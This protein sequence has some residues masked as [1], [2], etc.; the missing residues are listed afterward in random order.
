MATPIGT[1]LPAAGIVARIGAFP[2]LLGAHQRPLFGKYAGTFWRPA[3][4]RG[5][6]EFGTRAK[7]YRL[8]RGNDSG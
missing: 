2:P 4:V 3:H 8:R 6:A 7:G 5:E 1:P